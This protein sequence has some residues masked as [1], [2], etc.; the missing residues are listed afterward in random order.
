MRTYTLTVLAFN[1]PSA[2]RAKTLAILAQPS[3]EALGSCSYASLLQP[4][5]MAV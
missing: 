4:T 3:Q 1:Y 5:G 2:E